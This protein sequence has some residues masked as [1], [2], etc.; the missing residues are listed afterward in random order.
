MSMLPSSM[1]PLPL[2]YRRSYT[3]CPAARA[4][5]SEPGLGQ[6][7]LVQIDAEPRSVAEGDPAVLARRQRLGEQEI[8]TVE[9]P[10]GRIG[11]ELQERRAGQPRRPGG[12]CGDAP[13]A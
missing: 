3:D 11:W 9:A 4:A 2:S 8:A 10:L 13:P 12:V 7:V 6:Q 5:R 1:N